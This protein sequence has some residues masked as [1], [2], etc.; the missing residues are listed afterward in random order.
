M[1]DA[2]RTQVEVQRQ[3]PA[4]P[5]SATDFRDFIEP[6]WSTMAYFARRAVPTGAWEDVLQDALTTA[7]RKRRQYD[8]AKGSPRNWLLAIVAD[9]V[10][11]RRRNPVAHDVELHDIGVSV[12]RTES[13]DIRQAVS[14]LA[15]R[16]RMA[17]TL[18]Y[19]LALSTDETAQV[20][21]CS[22]GTV[23]STLSDAKRQLKHLLGEDYGND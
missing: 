20:M 2:L 21:K 4:R 5:V 11:K 1:E 22:A 8:Q 10:Y 14:R 9:K 7:W 19:Y 23:K 17:V 3:S 16:Q 13:V 12:D 15:P 6:H 18:R